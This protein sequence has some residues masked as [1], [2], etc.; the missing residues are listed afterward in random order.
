MQK[1]YEDTTDKYGPCGRRGAGVMATYVFTLG[2]SGSLL[3]N[4][5]HAL[6]DTTPCEQ[7]RHLPFIQPIKMSNSGKEQRNMNKTFSYPFLNNTDHLSVV[8]ICRM[9]Y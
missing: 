5:L 3:E 7:D 9:Q 4:R 1:H 2:L 6:A 8:V